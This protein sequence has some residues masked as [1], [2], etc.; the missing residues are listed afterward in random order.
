[1]KNAFLR[2]LLIF[3]AGAGCA[4]VVAAA[5]SP[6]PITPPQFQER[7]IAV[8]AELEALGQYPA[9]FEDGQVGLFTDPIACV[10]NPP[11]PKLPMGAVNPVLLDKAMRAVI[12]VQ[13]GL[14][15]GEPE[16]VYEI[17]KCKPFR[18]KS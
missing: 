15:A 16:L 5:Y 1:M 17:A 14:L 9:L 13:H 3:G 2:G 7:V 18:G 10:P 8:L 12:T 11:R 6:G 4:S